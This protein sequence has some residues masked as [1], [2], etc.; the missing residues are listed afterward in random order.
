MGKSRSY[1]SK[2]FKKELGFDLSKFIVRRKLEE[3]K[4][5]LAYTDKPISEISEYLCFSSQSYFQNLFKNKYGVTPYEYRRST[6]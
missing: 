3:G 4:S 1:I 2:K 6:R 5:L